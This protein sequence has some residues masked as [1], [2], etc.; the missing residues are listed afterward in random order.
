M[1]NGTITA[2][3]GIKILATHALRAPINDAERA[4]IT[5]IRD[6]MLKL[7]STPAPT[8]E[9]PVADTASV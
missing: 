1:Q 9:A 3:E 6:G 8:A 5:Q 7:A 2:E 4:Q